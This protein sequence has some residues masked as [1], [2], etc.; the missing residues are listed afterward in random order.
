MRRARAVRLGKN[1][2]P[3]LDWLHAAHTV[4]VASLRPSLPAGDEWARAC[5]ARAPFPCLHFSH[6]SRQIDV[7]SRNINVTHLCS[8]CFIVLCYI[9]ISFYSVFTLSSLVPEIIIPACH[10]KDQMLLLSFWCIV[11]Y[12]LLGLFHWAENNLEKENFEFKACVSCDL[13]V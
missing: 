7:I 10:C 13:K 12:E 2:K 5:L 11:F 9:M 3:L 8:Y 4:I 6:C 1:W